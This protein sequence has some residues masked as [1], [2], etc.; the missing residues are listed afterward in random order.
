[1]K[2]RKQIGNRPYGVADRMSGIRQ[3]SVVAVGLAL[4]AFALPSVAVASI[5]PDFNFGSG[6]TGAGQFQTPTGVAV[7]DTTGDVYVAD[8]GNHRIERF[9]SAGA[10]IST[11][12]LD[13]DATNPS[14]GF[15]IC[16]AESGHECQQGTSGGAAGAMNLPV[17]VAVDDSGGPADGSVY[18]V[19]QNSY[20]V[21]R[22]TE[23]GAFVLTWGRQVNLTSGGNVCTAASGDTCLPGIP[24]GTA[25]TTPATPTPAGVFGN[26]VTTGYA[27][28]IAV[29]GSGLV[30][31]SD[32][33]AI[34]PWAGCC[35][36]GSQTGRI[37]IFN[38]QGMFVAQGAN[39][40]EFF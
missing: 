17:A 33:W 15:E 40:S 28:D 37:Q 16:T 32:P 5:E 23:A 1:M 7:N 24:S 39:R 6:G 22:F 4:V 9:D 29:D 2:G 19:E 3:A 11:W 12:G 18:V 10:F 20:R 36:E 13:V 31:V 25:T 30:Y 26:W 38:A 8:S 35:A 34:N 14:T 21:D 27:H